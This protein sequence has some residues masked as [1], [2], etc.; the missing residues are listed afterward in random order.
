[1]EWGIP[2]LVSAGMEMGRAQIW[3]LR[4]CA[5]VG[6]GTLGLVSTG[7]GM[8][9]SGVLEWGCGGTDWGLRS[10]GAHVPRQMWGSYPMAMRSYLKVA[11]THDRL[12]DFFRPEAGAAAAWDSTVRSW[13]D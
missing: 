12:A 1:M 10:G 13:H 4:G 2:G 9:G 5:E 11:N 7:T 8:G 6:W 3:R